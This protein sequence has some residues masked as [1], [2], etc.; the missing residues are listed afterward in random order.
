MNSGAVMLLFYLALMV[1]FVLT[2]V[3]FFVVLG[4][5]LW[6]RLNRIV[7]ALERMSPRPKR[8]VR[9][10][11]LRKGHLVRNAQGDGWSDA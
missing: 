5:A 2:V 4:L 9:A 8:R 3:G 10:P 6:T 11:G 7:A 1:G